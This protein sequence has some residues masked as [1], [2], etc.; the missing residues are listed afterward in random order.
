MLFIKLTIKLI[1]SVQK[2]IFF[3]SLNKT[4]ELPNMINIYMTINDYEYYIFDNN[5]SNLI[6]F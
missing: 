6:F 3:L 5:F 2:N 1:S 4:T